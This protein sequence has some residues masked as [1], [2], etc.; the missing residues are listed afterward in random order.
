MGARHLD[1][2]ERMIDEE[3]AIQMIDLMLERLCEESAS[4]T[5]ECAAIR[6]VCTHS[7]ALMPKRLAVLAAHREATLIDFVSATG[8]FHELWVYEYADLGH[9]IFAFWRMLVHAVVPNDEDAIGEC[10]LRR[11]ERDTIG[12]SIKRILHILEHRRKFWGIE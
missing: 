10:N 1:D 3:D 5:L 9:M 2:V 6:S 11:C 8:G 12:L 7:C 4:A